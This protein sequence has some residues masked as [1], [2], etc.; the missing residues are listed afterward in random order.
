[1]VACLR[2]VVGNEAKSEKLFRQQR[3][4]TLQLITLDTGWL[5]RLGR[6]VWF[7]K[8]TFKASSTVKKG[9]EKGYFYFVGRRVIILLQKGCA[10]R[11]CPDIVEQ[12]QNGYETF[13]RCGDVMAEEFNV[14]KES[15]T[16]SCLN[17]K[18]LVKVKSTCSLCKNYSIM[19]Q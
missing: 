13:A 7:V 12:T 11:L 6:P 5:L 10:V 19:R 17:I 1:M 3:F 16:N 18:S 4:V 15:A 9:E 2:L 8:Q 14:E